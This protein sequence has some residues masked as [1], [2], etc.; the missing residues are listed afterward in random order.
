MGRL[1]SGMGLPSWH[2][3]GLVR[4]AWKRVVPHEGRS[5]REELAFRMGVVPNDLSARNTS[6]PEKA[7]PKPL[8]FDYAERIVEAVRL[9]DPTFTIM[10]PNDSTRSP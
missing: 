10:D 7:N 8:T 9:D 2:A 5:Q 4:A 3:T 6:T 1:R